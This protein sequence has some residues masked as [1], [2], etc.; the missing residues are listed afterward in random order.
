MSS[1]NE[2]ISIRIMDANGTVLKVNPVVMKGSAFKFGSE[3]IGGTYFAEVRQGANRQVV[4]LIK[5][6]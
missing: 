6:N 2:P 3:L 5:L 1:S 4:K